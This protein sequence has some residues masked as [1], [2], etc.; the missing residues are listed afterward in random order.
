MNKK[1]IL[2]IRKQ[3]T[4]ANCALTRICGCYVDYEKNKRLQFRESFL[5][6]PEEEAFKYFDLFK[7]TL[8]GTVG[9]NLLRMSFPS[10]QNI[11]DGAQEFLLKLRGSKLEDDELLD[12]FYDKI[13]EH[14]V[15]AENYYIVLVHGVYDIPKR[16]SD[17]MELYDAS[18][19]MYEYILMS[20]CPVSLSK[21]GLS[22]DAKDNCIRERPRDWLVEMP[23]QGFL[24]PAFTD[25]STNIHEAVYFTKKTQELQEDLLEELF[26][27]QIPIAIAEQKELFRLILEDTLE[28][29]R[30]YET[31]RN[32]HQELHGMLAENKEEP[33]PLVLE[34]KDV[35]KVLERSG[36][37]HEKLE[38]F[39]QYFDENAGEDAS[40]LAMNITET[41]KLQIETPDLLIRVNPE[42]MDL[43]ETKMIDGRKCLVIVVDDS[44]E[45]NGMD[46]RTM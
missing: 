32:I 28:E 30:T 8:S 43:V 41:K 42:R 20:I 14:Y 39:E 35:K 17:G 16:S 9:R 23:E 2:E 45:V 3:F 22:Y 25:R 6:L 24:F 11:S 13:I 31:V 7:K 27:G 1:E 44:L 33:E 36:V 12:E 46:V 18:D 37:P 29:E 5:S 38:H 10:T 21:A 19:E 15:F 34:K 4:P 26:G 40:F